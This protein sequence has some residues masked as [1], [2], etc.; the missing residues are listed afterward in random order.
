MVH[1]DSIPFPSVSVYN[2]K[3]LGDFF[4][5]LII[6]VIIHIPQ[7]VIIA[8]VVAVV[9]VIRKKRKKKNGK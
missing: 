7:I 5:E 2:L 8:A 4:V 3:E 1:F 6:W 9:F